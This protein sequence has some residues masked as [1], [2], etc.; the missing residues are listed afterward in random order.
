MSALLVVYLTVVVAAA[1]GIA[2]LAGFVVLRLYRG[3]P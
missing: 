3:R 1:V 2:W